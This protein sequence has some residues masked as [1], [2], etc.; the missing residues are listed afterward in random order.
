MQK[1]LITGGAGF[2]GSNLVRLM[3][4]QG[5]QV[6]NVDSLTYAGNL[7]SLDDLAG[8]SSYRFSQTDITHFD[9]VR[10]AIEQFQPEKDKS[11]KGCQIVLA[12]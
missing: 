3:V 1:I 6:L 12:I 10:H 2:I 7:R 5:H 11:A 8:D 4:R 9:A